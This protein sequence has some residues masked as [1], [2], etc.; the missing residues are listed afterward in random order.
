MKS[1]GILIALLASALGIPPLSA[2]DLPQRLRGNDPAKVTPP[3]G[4]QVERPLG[5]LEKACRKMH[6]L[7]RAVYDGTK[8]LQKAIEGNA[9]KK[10]RPREVQTAVML[11]AKQRTIV[12]ETTKAIKIL[13]AEG[14]AVA[15]T[16]VFDQVR[17]DMKNV[18]RRLELRDVGRANQAL[19]EDIID[20]LQEMIKSLRSK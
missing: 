3:R 18:Q 16:E 20:T 13:E 6:D 4:E 14:S 15:F 10:P 11:A 12:E 9:D 17:D 7:Q 2:A 19:Q 1:L 5:I 8:A